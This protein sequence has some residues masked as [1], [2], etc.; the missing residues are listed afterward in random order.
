MTLPSKH[1]VLVIGASG[2]LGSNVLLSIGDY[3][4][5]IA[6]SSSRRIDVH[7]LHSIQSDLRQVMA[8]LELIKRVRPGLVINC[9]ALTNL[10]LCEQNP[11]LAERLNTQVPA[12]LAEG[13]KLVD[14]KFVHVSSDAVHCGDEE[15][16]ETQTEL[17]P[18]SVYGATKAHAEMQ[19]Q[20][21]LPSALIVRTNIIGWSPTKER[22]LLEFFLNSLEKDR[23]VRGFHD[24]YFRPISAS[25]FWSLISAWIA[26]D[27]SGV[28]HAFGSELI[29]KYEFGRRVAAKFA[30][31]PGL[32]RPVSIDDM[33]NHV[34][35]GKIMNMRPSTVQEPSLLD[36]D[37][38]L[39][40]L[41]AQ[42]MN[43][44]RKAISEI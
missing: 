40:T 33:E 7:G 28:V 23:S 22:S 1:P 37:L 14:A 3:H 18:C 9:A 36:I 8:P 11:I 26:T 39:N 25:N 16:L 38:A 43:G 41:F 30:F 5:C 2:F 19:I 15:T 35:R 32:I 27:T 29:S 17:I 4:N 13:C 34:A 42:H 44:Y 31:D 24:V 20:R 10:E 12:E 21:I 6:H